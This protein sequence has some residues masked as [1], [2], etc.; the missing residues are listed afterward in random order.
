MF[1]F[2]V[3]GGRGG[4]APLILARWFSRQ[5]PITVTSYL[6]SSEVGFSEVGEQS[7]FLRVLIFII[8]IYLLYFIK[9]EIIY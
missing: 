5:W 2:F 3:S 1:A 4:F 8:F 9:Q 7:Q 6:F